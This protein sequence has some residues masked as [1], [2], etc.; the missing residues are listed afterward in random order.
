MK[1]AIKDQWLA[2]LR[3]GEYPKGVGELRSDPDEGEPR[4]FCC[5][6]VLLDR[7]VLAGVITWPE[8]NAGGYGVLPEPVARW[9]GLDTLDPVVPNVVESLRWSMPSD[10]RGDPVTQEGVRLSQYNDATNATFADIADLIEAGIPGEEEP[11]EG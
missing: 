2:D 9:A 3:S 8:V 10:R 5:L 7:A 11:G 4:T 1:K 6:G